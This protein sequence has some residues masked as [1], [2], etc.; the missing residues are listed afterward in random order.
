MHSVVTQTYLNT[1]FVG[2][3]LKKPEK[4]LKVFLEFYACCSIGLFLGSLPTVVYAV[5]V[6]GARGGTVVEALCYKPEGRGI[7]SQWC[8]CNFSLT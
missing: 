1:V 8:H 3:G 5:V 4:F 6:V 7:D 2:N